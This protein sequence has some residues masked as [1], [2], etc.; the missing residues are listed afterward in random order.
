MCSRHMH[1]LLLDAATKRK[2]RSLTPVVVKAG[3]LITSS[4]SQFLIA[5]RVK[6]QIYWGKYKIIKL[7]TGDLYEAR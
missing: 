2:Y 4:F 1:R 7:E 6:L 3:G 5:L